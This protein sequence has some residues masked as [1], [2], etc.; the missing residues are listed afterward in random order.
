MHVFKIIFLTIVELAKQV[1]AFP[2]SV[3]A[4]LRKSRRLA[5]VNQVE[6]ERLDR[7]RHPSKYVGKDG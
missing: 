5:N 2:A 7:L 6:A 4:N 1:R 3:I